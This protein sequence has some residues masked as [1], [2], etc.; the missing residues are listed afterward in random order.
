MHLSNDISIPVLKSYIE[1]RV[2]IANVDAGH[3][4]VLAIGVAEDDEDVLYVSDPGFERTQY[5]YQ[6]DVVGWRIFDMT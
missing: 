1:T 2:V 3:H 5:S 6:S 4:F